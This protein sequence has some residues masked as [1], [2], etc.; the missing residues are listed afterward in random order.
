MEKEVV[1]K[2]SFPVISVAVIALI[3]LKIAEVVPFVNWSWWLIFLPIWGVLA[4]G[5]AIMLIIFLFVVL[6]EIWR[7]E[8]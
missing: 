4:L 3:I 7:N 1:Y 5:I 6:R 8:Y 2:S